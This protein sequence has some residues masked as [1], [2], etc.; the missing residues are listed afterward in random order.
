VAVLAVAGLLVD[1]AIAVVVE[2]VAANLGA[3]ENGAD[4][5]S[6]LANHEL[7]HVHD[8]AALLARGADADAFVLRIA[9]VAIARHVVHR[10]RAALRVRR[11]LAAIRTATASGTAART[12]VARRHQAR[13][14][15]VH[16]AGGLVP[17]GL[18]ATVAAPVA[19][20]IATGS[21]RGVVVLRTAHSHH[22]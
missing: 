10:A 22:E 20:R 7:A 19:G 9:G 3:G 11:V 4:A 17:G 1:L 8:L 18:A 12:G 2:F 5:R 21:A 13:T 6:P 16:R 15:R 14:R